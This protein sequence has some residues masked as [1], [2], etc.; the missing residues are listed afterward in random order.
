M[1]DYIGMFPLKLVVFPGEQLNLH[2]FEPRYK[3]LI[4]DCVREN[5]TFGIPAFINEEIAQIG[6]E[7]RLLR[8]EKK[9]PNGEMDIRT[10]GIGIF[11]VVDFQSV[12]HGK[13]YAGATIEP[14]SVDYD[15]DSV[16][17][18]C[19]LED[20]KELFQTLHLHKKPPDDPAKF[21]SFDVAHYVG[22]SLAQEYEFLC[23]PQERARQQ[24]LS[25]H[26]KQLLPVVREMESLRER[27]RLNGYFK[28]L[29]PPILIIVRC[30]ISRFQAEP[31]AKY[32]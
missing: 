3:E 9:Y 31:K 12:T 5:K 29:N 26:L 8:I 4:N 30:G 13:L 28:H 32:M 14:Q 27:A 25:Q 21:I 2:I 11:K 17:N 16:Q 23:L 19:I 7:I 22:F 20:L 15:G 1:P 18:E 24:Y 6:T 10:Q